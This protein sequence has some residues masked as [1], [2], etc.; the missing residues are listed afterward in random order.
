MLYMTTRSTGPVKGGL[1]RFKVIF[2]MEERKQETVTLDS[3]CGP[4]DEG[5]PV[6][7]V[8]HPDEDLDPLFSPRCWRPF[9][10]AAILP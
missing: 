1:L 9:L 10:L 6:L 7:T 2:V 5:E 8:M 4:G 3:I